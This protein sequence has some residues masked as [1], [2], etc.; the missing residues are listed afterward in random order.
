M[1][2]AEQAFAR[3]DELMSRQPPGKKIP[4]YAPLNAEQP[5]PPG[6]D[7]AA[8]WDQIIWGMWAPPTVPLGLYQDV[9][10]AR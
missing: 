10:A 3:L 5:V 8:M 7:Y 9:E 2:S 4:K 1:M 6:D